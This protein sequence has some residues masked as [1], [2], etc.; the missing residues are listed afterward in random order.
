VAPLDLGSAWK[1]SFPREQFSEEM[2]RL[3]SWA[4]EPKLRF[5]SGEAIYEKSIDVP[6]AFLNGGRNIVLDFGEGRPLDPVNTS[7]PGMRAWMEGPVREAAVVYVNGQSAGYIW[8]PPY[9]VAVNQFLHPG[10]NQLRIVVGNSAINSL[11]GQAAPDYKLLNLRY[12]VRFA[13]QDMN[14]LKPL[15]SGLVGPVRL[16]AE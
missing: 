13:P 11:A 7:A 5:Y 14:G 10:A 2:A 15:P 6:P 3:H 4:D 8:H 12:G 16:I 1:V 9:R